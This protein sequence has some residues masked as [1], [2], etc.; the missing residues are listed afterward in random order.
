LLAHTYGDG[1]S[2]G[3]ESPDDPNCINFYTQQK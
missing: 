3:S 2:G 1:S